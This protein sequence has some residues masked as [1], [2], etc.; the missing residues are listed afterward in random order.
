MGDMGE[1][2]GEDTGVVAEGATVEEE[3]EEEGEEGGMEEEAEEGEEGD[4]EEEGAEEEEEGAMEGE[5]AEEGEEGVMGGTTIGEA[6][7]E[8]GGVGPTKLS[9]KCSACVCGC[10]KK[11]KRSKN[12]TRQGRRLYQRSKRKKDQQEKRVG[13]VRECFAE[14]AGANFG[15]GSGRVCFSYRK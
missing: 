8:T 7:G 6:T 10:G 14:W 1:E 5:G 12:Q 11:A 13:W 9:G 2:E 15:F 3:E 4:M